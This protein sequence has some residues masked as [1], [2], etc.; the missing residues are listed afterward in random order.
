MN[1]SV[2]DSRRRQA[3]SGARRRGADSCAQRSCVRR[4]AHL[5][6]GIS[7]RPPPPTPANRGPRSS[8]W[9][10]PLLHQGTNPALRSEPR[11]GRVACSDLAPYP[12]RR[13][14]VASAPLGGVRQPLR[15]GANPTLRSEPRR[16]WVACSDSGWAIHRLSGRPLGR[17][18]GGPGPGTWGFGIRV[19]RS[20][21]WF[22]APP[23]GHR[24]A[25]DGRRNG[26][27]HCLR[28][29]YTLNWV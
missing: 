23:A 16:G 5:P 19:Y 1:R 25:G 10:S 3:R 20:A 15:Q 18:G 11:R 9:A 17:L 27:G 6:R 4:G 21:Y 13:R 28:C 26:A 29:S 7:P 12:R 22:R 8:W 2:P 14:T 24:V